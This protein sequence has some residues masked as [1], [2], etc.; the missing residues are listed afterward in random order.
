MP[1]V[2]SGSLDEVVEDLPA[3]LQVVEGADGRDGFRVLM[4]GEASAAHDY[5][6]LAES[7]LRWG[8]RIGVPLALVILLACSAPWQRHLCR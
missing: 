3:L 7:D 5:G 1:L 2:L 6:E 8:E 4:V